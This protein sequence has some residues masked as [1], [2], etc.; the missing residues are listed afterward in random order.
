MIREGKICSCGTSRGHW[1]RVGIGSINALLSLVTVGVL[2]ATPPAMLH[3]LDPGTPEGLQDLLRHGSGPLPIVSGHRGGAWHGFPENCIATFERTLEHTHAMLEIDPRRAKDGGIVVHHDTTLDRTTTGKGRVQEFTVAELKQFRLRDLD[4]KVTEFR[5]S[6]LDEIIDWARGKAILVLDQKD[7]SAVDRA[8]IVTRHK[9]EAFVILI[10]S[11]FQD[12]QAVHRLNPNIAMEV[13]I[14][15]QARAEKFDT[16]GVPWRNV[17]AFVGHTPPEESAIYD[18][19]H[20]KGVRCI[21]GTSRNLDRRF[22]TD[23]V[24]DLNKLEPQYRALLRRGADLI[25]TDLPAPLGAML[26]REAVVPEALERYLHVP[27]AEKQ[28]RP[29]R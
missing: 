18:Y 1:T 13:M 17:V 28:S 10:V 8:R 14:P 19:I 24:T 11:S 7:V 22:I 9:A 26:Y 5:M 3:R 20:G 25:E 29:K 23:K 27:K 4:G 6:T 16:L 2:A 15:T 21:V 12:V